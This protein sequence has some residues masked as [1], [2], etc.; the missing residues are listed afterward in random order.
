MLPQVFAVCRIVS[1]QHCIRAASS[2]SGAS[3]LTKLA[4]EPRSV[5]N[6]IR[7][8]RGPGNKKGKTAGR[9]QK[10]H[11]SRSGGGDAYYEGGQ[12]PIHIRFPKV[13]DKSSYNL[14]E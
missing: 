10:G 12:T 3:I 8:G 1:R 4:P 2:V 6:S 13:G 11:N 7:V 5:I 14:W 9:G